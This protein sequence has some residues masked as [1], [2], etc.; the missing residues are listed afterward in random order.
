MGEQAEALG[1][2]VYP[3][4]AAAEV[5]IILFCVYRKWCFLLNKQRIVQS[6]EINISEKPLDFRIAKL[7]GI[8][9]RSNPKS[10]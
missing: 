7:E 5:C 6:K 2:E 4:Y 3:G 10:T 8:L 9:E 1:V